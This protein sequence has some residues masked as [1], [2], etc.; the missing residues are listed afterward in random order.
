MDAKIV[1]VRSNTSN[2]STVSNAI[3]SSGVEKSTFSTASSETIRLNELLPRLPE[4]CA[5]TKPRTTKSRSVCLCD[6]KYLTSCLAKCLMIMVA[7]CVV[8]AVILATLRPHCKRAAV[9]PVTRDECL[10]RDIYFYLSSIVA[11][12]NTLLILLYTFHVIEK[13][14]QSRW[15]RFEL[16]YHLLYTT[17][18][19]IISSLTL[20][21]ST[22]QV[23][24][25]GIL[26]LA[27]VF[28]GI[29]IVFD[30]L[31]KL[32]TGKPAQ[33][34]FDDDDGNK[35]RIGIMKLRFGV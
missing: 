31:I 19:T 25:L 4:L 1:K 2:V 32:C 5:R 30:R 18:M 14:N 24:L 10:L 21:K 34:A 12:L 8:A 26:G 11:G 17:H 23:I 6:W 22:F 28:K 7:E 15:L 27:V 33:E 16:I 20:N 9:D 35:T 29:I 13:F 3:K